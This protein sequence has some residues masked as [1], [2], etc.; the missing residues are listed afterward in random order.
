MYRVN[1]IGNATWVSNAYGV[2]DV[3]GIFA[4]KHP[5]KGLYRDSSSNK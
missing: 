1:V 2:A 4:D 3:E 5:S